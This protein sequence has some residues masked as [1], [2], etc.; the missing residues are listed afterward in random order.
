MVKTTRFF[1]NCKCKQ[2]YTHPKTYP[3]CITCGAIREDQP[4]SKVEEAIEFIKKFT[5]TVEE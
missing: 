4:D 2:H 1:W 5:T 3:E